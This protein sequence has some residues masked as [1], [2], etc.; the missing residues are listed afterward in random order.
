[1]YSATFDGTSGSRNIRLGGR[2]DDREDRRETLERARRE[3]KQRQILRQQQA[4]ARTVQAAVRAANDLYRARCAHRVAWDK[5]MHD[6]AALR[7]ILL[8]TTKQF[9]LPPAVLTSLLRQL[10]FFVQPSDHSD[11]ARV[12]RFC[13]L[14]LEPGMWCTLHEPALGIA[15]DS[16]GARAAW[17]NRMQRLLRT[18]LWVVDT[19]ISYGGARST[20]TVADGAATASASTSTSISAS[21][22][23]GTDG[24]LSAV[25]RVLSIAATPSAVQQDIDEQ[26]RSAVAFL[27]FCLFSFNRL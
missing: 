25:L 20:T 14:M 12:D 22:V 15:A 18:C 5:K 7:P 26:M 27:A 19:D 6:I 16:T 24:A 9:K 23:N 8:A 13:A 2:R 11:G 4:A 21:V 3:R 1:M 17:L 10:L